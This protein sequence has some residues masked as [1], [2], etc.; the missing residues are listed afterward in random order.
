ME[1][2]EMIAMEAACCS[3]MAKQMR[4]IGM[5]DIKEMKNGPIIVVHVANV[6]LG[7]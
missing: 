6:W 7:E 2:R 1:A 5:F 3:A 4:G